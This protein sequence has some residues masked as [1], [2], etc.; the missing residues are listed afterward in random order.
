MTPPSTA[1]PPSR[2]WLWC[3]I[4]LTA[5]IGGLGAAELVAALIAPAASPLLVVGALVIDLVPGWVKDAVIALFGTADKLVLLITLGVLVAIV[6]AFAGLLE[7][8]RRPWGGALIAVVGLMGIV[9][10]VTRAN[11]GQLAALP[12]LIAIVVGMLVLRM[13]A[14]RL[15]RAGEAPAT[16]ESRRAFLVA[17]S[18]SAGLGV[19]AI[20]AGRALTAGQR[21][22]QTVRTAFKLPAAASPA[23]ALSPSTAFEV[24]GLSP[25]VT[26]NREFYRIDT[27]LQVPVV[28][29]KE[30][31]L[32]IVGMVDEEVSITF[33]E[34]AALP[35]E[36][37]YT[38]LACVSNYV[39]GELIGNAKWLGYPIRELLKRAGPHPKA[40]MV[41][42][43]SVDGFTAGTPLSVLTD[44]RNAILALGMNGQ[45][46]P[47]E[48]GYPV[49]M[50]VPGLYGYVSATKWVNRLEV[51]TFS[52][53]SAYW[54]ERGWS[55]R[56]PVKLSSRIDVPRDGG[57]PVKAGTATVAGVAWAQH[58]GISAVQVRVDDGPWNDAELADA[59]SADTWRQWKWDWPAR[60]GH[61]VLTVRATDANGTV[62]TAKVA[63]VVPDGATGLHSVDV[64]VS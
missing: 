41:L 60:A 32:E 19:I 59:I 30:W 49:R 61:H 29:P 21:A 52:Q 54:T 44:D 8:A 39:G 13:L 42:S 43:T 58:T 55:E 14:R 62:Q 64:T 63:D 35:L 40:D 16:S 46:L 5:V 56:G 27:A 18:A 26:P 24:S 20:V 3:A 48:H 38:T 47:F 37:S 45:P 36:E 31:K 1:T 10:A 51:T 28:D 53:H 17:A 12:S 6:A 4:G 23:S 33:D 50:V 7:R 11:A 2:R 34:L 9:A 25:L 22:T 57:G 15:D